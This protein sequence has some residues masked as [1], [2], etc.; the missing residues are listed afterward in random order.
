MLAF[1]DRLEGSDH[2]AVDRFGSYSRTQ[3]SFSMPRLQSDRF[4]HPVV[5]ALG[6]ADG[7]RPRSGASQQLYV[8]DLLSEHCFVLEV[9]PQ[10]LAGIGFSNLSQLLRQ[11]LLQ[12]PDNVLIVP[13]VLRTP[14]QA[15][16]AKP[17][18]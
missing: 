2:K 4:S 7:L 18:Q 6:L 17:M 11:V 8:G 5:L 1:W 15:A 10:T 12:P 14:F 3:Q 9:D 16:V 13:V